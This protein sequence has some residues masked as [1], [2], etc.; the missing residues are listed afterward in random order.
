MEIRDKNGRTE[1]EFLAEYK[2]KN[3]PRPSLTADIILFGDDRTKVLLIRR[4]GH[5]FLGQWAFPGGFAESTETVEATAERELEEETGLRGIALRPVGIFS[6]PG[7]DPRG[8]TVSVA[9]SADV[10]TDECA[11]CAGDDAAAAEWFRLETAADG[12]PSRIRLDGADARICFDW[13]RT[14]TAWNIRFRSD[15][16]LAF[17]HAEMLVKG[18]GY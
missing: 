16:I 5:P 1:A 6:R 15:A 11:A 10:K 18:L 9:Y 17:D 14:G 4:G 12:E 7:R 3:Y 13:E 8:W 2:T